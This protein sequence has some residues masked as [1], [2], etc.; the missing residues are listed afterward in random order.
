MHDRAVYEQKN[1]AMNERTNVGEQ[2]C[3]SEIDSI[4]CDFKIKIVFDGKTSINNRNLSK[5]KEEDGDN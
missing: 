3:Q 4:I 5:I 2:L 1:K